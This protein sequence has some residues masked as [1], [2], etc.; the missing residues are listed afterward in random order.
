MWEI[1]FEEIQ[2]LEKIGQGGFGVVYKGLW[3][4][5]FGHIVYIYMYRSQ[6]ASLTQYISY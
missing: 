2:L 3:R 5:T 1:E 6:N 4:G